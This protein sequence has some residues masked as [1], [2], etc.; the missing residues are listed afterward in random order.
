MNEITN[1]SRYYDGRITGG[2]KGTLY[3]VSSFAGELDESHVLTDADIFALL[4]SGQ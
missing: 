1:A 4:E 3:D 2:L